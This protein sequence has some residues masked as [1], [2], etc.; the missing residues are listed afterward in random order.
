MDELLSLLDYTAWAT[1]R[2]LDAALAL[3]TEELNRDL[4]SSHGG[5]SGTLEHLYGADVIWT[6]RLCARPAIHFSDL[7]ALPPLT[8]LKV[9]WLAL[10]EGR[11]DF[12]AGMKPNESVVYANLNGEAQVGSVGEIVRHI[13][14][15]GTYHRGQVATLMR[16]LGYAAPN[17]DLIAFSR[18]QARLRGAEVSPAKASGPRV[19]S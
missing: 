4:G 14:N 11:R 16:Q 18:L 2:L 9:Q 15:H 10:Q 12:A 13:V 3:T 5:V 1:T 6:A 17:T 8:T 19:V 7:P